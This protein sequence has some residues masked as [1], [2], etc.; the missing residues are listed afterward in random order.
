MDAQ[1]R[2]LPSWGTST[3]CWWCSSVGASLRGGHL[4]SCGSYDSFSSS[5]KFNMYFRGLNICFRHV[6][7]LSGPNTESK[8]SPLFLSFTAG[9]HLFIVNTSPSFA[10]S[11]VASLSYSTACLSVL[12]L[13]PGT[14]SCDSSKGMNSLS[15]SEL[16]HGCS[17]HLPGGK[18]ESEPYCFSWGWRQNPSKPKAFSQNSYPHKFL[19]SD[20][21]LQYTVD[22]WRMQGSGVLIPTQ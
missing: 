11:N 7:P 2:I 13:K 4:Y 18:G 15:C 3:G 14:R 17:L 8:S 22:I 20:I 12:R 19:F 6:I 16:S 5:W 1:N 21:F 10:K 9:L